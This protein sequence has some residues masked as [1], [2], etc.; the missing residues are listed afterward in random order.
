M[1]SDKKI[2]QGHGG[3][4]GFVAPVQIHIKDPELLNILKSDEADFLLENYKIFKGSCFD[5]IYDFWRLSKVVSKLENKHDISFLTD[6][7]DR[8]CDTLKKH[9]LEVRDLTGS[10]YN[11][12]MI[13]DVIHVEQISSSTTVSPYISETIRPAI[14]LNKRLVL[15]SE[16]VVTRSSNSQGGSL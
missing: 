8:F 9:G 1:N 15:K 16:V 7:L 12:G 14:Y 10:A 2:D 3:A 13:V 11:D 6:A 5:L 4:K